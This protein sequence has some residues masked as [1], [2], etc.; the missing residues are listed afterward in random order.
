MGDP[1]EPVCG[2]TVTCNG[3]NVDCGCVI[4]TELV[5]EGRDAWIELGHRLV[6]SPFAAKRLAELLAKLMAEYESR[7][8]E[9][10]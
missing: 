5:V 3:T 8:G 2:G 10:K 7:H 9:L 6:M 1:G 4:P